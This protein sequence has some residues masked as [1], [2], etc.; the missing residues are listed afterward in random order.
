MPHYLGIEI[1]GTKLQL[2]VG[3]GDGRPLVALERR[4]IDPSGG[5][6]RIAEQ[7]AAAGG[8]LVNRFDVRGV[9]FGFGGPVDPIDGRVI[10]SHQVDGW[11]GFPLAS[12]STQ[13]L[14][15]PA[16]VGNDC[17]LA[18]LAE[19]LFGAG[20]GAGRVF[21]VTV[22]TGVGGGFVVDRRLEGGGRPAIA[23]IGH[24]RPGL[25]CRH[26][27]ATVESMASGW[28]I[29]AAARRLLEEDSPGPTSFGDGE[30]SM[31]PIAVEVS[32]SDIQDLLVRCGH[33]L[34]R[35]TAKDVGQAAADG[36]RLAGGVMAHATEVL[37]WAIAQVVTLLAP[38]HVIVGGGV[39]LQGETLFLDPVRRAAA[40]Y[41]FPPLAT[42]YTI[43][44]A[45]LGEEVVVHGALAF[46][47]QCFG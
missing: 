11:D 36:N 1:G 25:E 38:H 34:E 23:E 39:S 28:G 9:G 7:I 33:D 37:G 22:G 40:R 29:L 26:A 18:A 16:V 27:E 47:R 19:A 45:L 44:P 41:V 46:A 6:A 42:S 10:K 31:P 2:G 43:C 21:Y 3:A 12:W 20:K 14:G 4:E 17:D 5:A 32:D 24:L 15:R 35:L 30:Y 13:R 8:P